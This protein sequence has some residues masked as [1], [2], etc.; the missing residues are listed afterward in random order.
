MFVEETKLRFFKLFKNIP[1]SGGNKMGIKRCFA[2]ILTGLLVLTTGC[3]GGG[4]KQEAPKFPTKA[5]DMT[6]LFGAGGGAD[7]IARKLGD[8]ASREIG[9]PIVAITVL[10]VAGP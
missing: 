4:G 1:R 5:L 3:A 10:A 8:L 9:Q 2:I 7:V 6:I